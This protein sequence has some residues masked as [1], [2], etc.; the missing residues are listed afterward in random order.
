MH[1]VRAFAPRCLIFGINTRPY[2]HVV[3]RALQDEKQQNSREC[4]HIRYRESGIGIPFSVISF[5]MRASA[6]GLRTAVAAP[7][8][9][10]IAHS[11]GS[12]PFDVSPVPERVTGLSLM[13]SRAP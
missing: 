8:L 6:S 5:L 7:V 3:L 13:S 11:R 10:P 9:T 2:E 1:F 4:L 12:R